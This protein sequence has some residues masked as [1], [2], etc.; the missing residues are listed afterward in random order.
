MLNAMVWRCV[1]SFLSRKAMLTLSQ[2]RPTGKPSLSEGYI[3][4][5]KTLLAFFHYACGGSSPFSIDWE[6]DKDPIDVISPDLVDYIQDIKQ[7]VAQQ[8]KCSSPEILALYQNP[9]FY[10]RLEQKRDS[11]LGRLLQCTEIR[12][13]GAI[14]CIVETGH[15][16]WDLLDRLNI[17]RRKTSLYHRTYSDHR[18][19]YY[20]HDRRSNDCNNVMEL[21][22]FN[23]VFKILML[24]QMLETK[25]S[26]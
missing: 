6:R 9:L 23:L 15:R 17:L 26:G 3:H 11:T 24:N 13:I 19:W 12:C 7:E 22:L 2:S 4:A 20:T 10:W 1:R 21:R 14:S 5:C 25:E 8:S 16:M 18:Q